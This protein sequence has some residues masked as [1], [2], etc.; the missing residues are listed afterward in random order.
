[1]S[2]G[3]AFEP[4]TEALAEGAGAA[5]ASLVGS[6]VGSGAAVTAALVAVAVSASAGERVA[7]ESTEVAD[8]ALD[9]EAPSS[10]DGQPARTSNSHGNRRPLMAASSHRPGASGYDRPDES[11]PLE[12]TRMSSGGDDLL[13]IDRELLALALEQA[14][15]SVEVLDPDLRI[16]WVNAAFERLHG[17]RREDVVG[18]S[19]AALGLGSSRYASHHAEAQRAVDEGRS[20]TG[21]IVAVRPDGAETIVQMTVSPLRDGQGQ[22]RGCVAIKRDQT[23]VHAVMNEQRRQS[24]ELE[25]I[26]DN[27]PVGVVVHGSGVLRYVN[28]RTSELLGVAREELVGQSIFRWLVTDDGEVVRKRMAASQR[29][30]TI[31]EPTE[32]QV[33]RGDDTEL[34]VRIYPAGAIAF[35]GEL[36]LCACLQDLRPERKSREASILEDRMQTIGQIAAGVAHEINNP[37]SWMIDALDEAASRPDAVD[38][39]R[40]AR[41][42]ADRIRHVVRELTLFTR[43]PARS[44][45]TT[46]IGEVIHSA[47]H[48]SRRTMEASARV[49]LVAPSQ[50][51]WVTGS[52]PKLG[53]VL[54]NLLLNAGAAMGTAQRGEVVVAWAAEGDRCRLTVSDDGR[55]MS[56]EV[57]DHAFDPFFTTRAASGGTG[58]GLPMCRNILTDLGGSIALD[59]AVGR[60]TTVT[61]L[62]PRAQPEERPAD[63]LPAMLSGSRCR[64]LVV[65]DQHMV[66]RALARRLR[67]L[68]HHVEQLDDGREAL[69]ALQRRPSPDVVLCDLMMPDFGGQELHARLLELH[70]EVAGR[71]VFMTGGAFTDE[72]RAFLEALDTPW[73]VK[74]FDDDELV[75][76][77]AAVVAGARV[78]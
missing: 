18:R 48:L 5:L 9:V 38:R 66:A 63:E 68:G 47:V 8:P 64:V 59:S 17:R 39:I 71:M 36:C 21:E 23:A 62:L 46:E 4:A 30:G 13:A 3:Q 69:E 43:D 14:G 31:P 56:S 44:D 2:A 40:E 54:L 55:G 72:A 37:L 53:Q 34:P 74:P 22:S 1:M 42:G 25:V 24:R 11:R 33:R 26:L 57:I 70:P 32:V 76:A 16:R 52:A 28:Q 41:D 29:T 27:V 50:E 60:G 12:E 49:R 51:I 75:R 78:R 73:L 35:R 58:L 7:L 77:L 65:D 67:K 10:E 19:P 6:M 45:A 20:W 61:V 15:D